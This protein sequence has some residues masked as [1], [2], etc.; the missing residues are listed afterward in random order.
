MR[1]LRTLTVSSALFALTAVVLPTTAQAAT[2]VVHCVIAYGHENPGLCDK[3]PELGAPV[4][5]GKIYPTSQPYGYGEKGLLFVEGYATPGTRVTVSATDGDLVISRTV[6]A[7]SSEGTFKADLKVTELGVHAA[8]GTNPFG[9]SV[10]TVSAVATNTLNEESAVTTTEIDKYAVDGATDGD[11]NTLDVYA[12]RLSGLRWPPKHWCHT[13]SAGMGNS[14]VG[15]FGG[16][17]DGRCSSLQQDG[18]GAAPD[19]SWVACLEETSEASGPRSLLPAPLNTPNPM[20]SQYCR[21]STRAAAPSGEAQLSGLAEDDHSGAF[22]HASEIAS[23]VIRVTQG[24]TVL[25]T[26]THFSRQNAT[27]GQWATTLRINDFSPNYP[28]GTPYAVTVTATD[29]TG[30]SATAAQTGIIVYPW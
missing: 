23:V 25:R 15:N 12:P 28:N 19:L 22:G 8:S 13:S 18:I 17:R 27:Q 14:S 4:Y 30:R 26:I 24:A 3:H 9:H 5:R 21:T 10:V 2:P 20:R 29:A 6:E 1:R 11:G 16:D 7:T